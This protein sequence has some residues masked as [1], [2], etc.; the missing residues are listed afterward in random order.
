MRKKGRIG[1]A[2]LLAAALAAG[3]MENPSRPLAEESGVTSFAIDATSLDGS[4]AF[5]GWG[6]SLCWFGNR[7]GGSEKT[8]EEAAKFLCN[9]EEGLGLDIIRFNIGG[10]DDPSHTH[11]TRTDS[12]MPGY[13]GSYDADTDTFDYDFTKDANQRNVLVKMLAQNSGLTLEAFSNSAPYFMTKSGCTS[14]TEEGASDN[15]KEDKYDDF[16]EYMAQVIKYY[17]ENYGIT[18]SSV[19]PMNEASSGWSISNNGNK[20]EGCTFTRGE[21]QSKMILAMDNALKNNQLGDVILAGTDESSP[22][23]ALQSL[24]QMSEEALAVLDRID[25]HTYQTP[26]QADVHKKAEELSKKLWMSESD[27]GTI[28]GDNAGEMGAALELA[29][30]ISSNMYY[31]N[32][33]AWI[34]WQAIGSYCSGQ[35]FEGNMDPE[36]LSQPELDTNGFWGVAYADMDQEKVV[37]T[38][39]YYGFGQFTRYIKKGDIILN[40][41]TKTLTSYDKEKNELK[42]VAVNNTGSSQTVKYDV[43]GLSW[44]NPAAEVIRTSGD[45][46]SGENWKKLDYIAADNSGFQAELIP[47]SITTFIVKETPADAFPSTASPQPAATVSPAPPAAPTAPVG[48]EAPATVTQVK[49]AKVSR[50]AV[51]LTW[52]KQDGVRYKVAYSA[53]KKKLSKIKNGSVKAA[54]GTKVASA[55]KNAVTIKKLKK[56]TAYY[57]KVCAYCTVDGKTVYGKYSA[58]IKFKTKKK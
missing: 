23:Q 26:K 28:S 5:E 57:V 24:E 4:D 18:F 43:A 49:A 44:K 8:S 1:I 38:K 56:N 35:P 17:K 53:D 20:Q 19:E 6:T 36:T 13:W 37:L 50:N 14:G 54:A 52:K 2:V 46:A 30:R 32:P 9:R 3:G 47:N 15:L 51:S 10:G 48:G 12:K 31:L 34:I 22:G 33:S 45:M 42:I 58:V 55:A 40:R 11:I 25:V 41:N 27:G 16:A 7:I 21:S 29:T 39:K